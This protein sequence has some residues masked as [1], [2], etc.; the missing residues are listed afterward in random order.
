MIDVYN[1]DS[2]FIFRNGS[3]TVAE[4]SFKDLKLVPMPG[5]SADDIREVGYYSEEFWPGQVFGK[6]RIILGPEREFT[7]EVTLRGYGNPDFQQYADIAPKMT[8]RCCGTEEAVA[9]VRKYQD[10][11]ELGGGNCGPEHGVVWDISGKRR[12]KAGSISYNGRFWKPGE[13]E[14]WCEELKAKHASK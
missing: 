4:M 6:S 12:K 10:Q 8:V 1:T 3:R 11:F 7:H 14:A 9:I 5:A 2:K 13:Y